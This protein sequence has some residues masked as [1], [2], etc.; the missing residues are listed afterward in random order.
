[1]MGGPIGE[2]ETTDEIIRIIKKNASSAVIVYGY[3]T[4]SN[5]DQE[6]LKTQLKEKGFR[7]NPSYSFSNKL[8]E[9]FQTPTA[10]T[11]YRDDKDDL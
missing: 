2:K 7:Q 8:R 11:Y 1:M 6:L 4:Y 10:F 5:K 9:P 3:D